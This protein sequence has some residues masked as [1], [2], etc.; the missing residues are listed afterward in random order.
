MEVLREIINKFN[1]VYSPFITD[2]ITPQE[3]DV[4]FVEGCVLDASKDQVEYLKTMRELSKRVIALGT[5][6]SFG[7]V[8]SMSSERQADPIS[9]YIEIDGFVPGCPPP[10]G[11]LNDAAIRLM[12]NKRI[13]LSDR[14]VCASCELRAENMQDFPKTI[15]RLDPRMD[16]PGKEAT[17]F[18]KDGVLCM[19]PVTRE[20][21]ESRCI[22]KNVP[23]EGCMG[24]PSQNFTSN[25]VNFFSMLPLSPELK[26]YQGML[27]RFSRPR[28]KALRGGRS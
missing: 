9:R 24:P 20:G 6:A 5:C 12:E 14:N 4:A 26:N 25:A 28:I 18:L 7:G 21:C 2:Q 16:I 19:G 3:N 11:L 15:D 22:K 27:F 10:P 17:C 8:A 13:V 1:I 23:C